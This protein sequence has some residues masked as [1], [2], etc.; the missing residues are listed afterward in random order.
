M[1][2][3]S[4]VL[5]L[6]TAAFGVAAKET[7]FIDKDS[8][9]KN[10]FE[11]QWFKDNIPFVEVPDRE[12]EEV[13]YYRWSSLKRHLRYTVAGAGYIITEF[14]H[15]VGYSQKFDTINAAAG[16]HIYEARWLRNA[17]YVQVSQNKL[18]EQYEIKQIKRLQDYINFW[19]RE[20]GAAQQYSEW[21][22]D[23]AYRAFLVNGDVE[24][25]KSQQ[26]GLVNNFNGW[27]DR[28]EPTLGLYFI[29]PHDDAM[30]MSASSMQTDDHY[31]GG[32][33]YRPSFNAEMYANAVAIFEIATLNGDYVTAEEFR[34]RASALRTSILTHLWDND[35]K[36]FYHMHRSVEY[37]KHKIVRCT[38][39]SSF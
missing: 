33:G 34:Q 19:S 8:K 28:F 35:R 20:G 39:D 3:N 26:L 2:A 24:F 4:V 14:V 11:P 18:R 21:I 27:N 22:A 5:I 29:S 12:I 36:F 31:H 38:F 13:Y 1:L 25:I 37:K 9:L 17:R 10:L 7:H 32:L 15:K 30:E 6:I 16:H 23:A